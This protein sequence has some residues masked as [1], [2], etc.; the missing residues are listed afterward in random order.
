[1]ERLKEIPIHIDPTT[2]LDILIKKDKDKNPL[3]YN[4]LGE[5]HLTN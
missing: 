2:T 3:K 4:F 5:K 1:M